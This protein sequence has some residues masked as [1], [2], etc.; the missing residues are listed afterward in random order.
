MSKYPHGHSQL[1]KG[2]IRY[3]TGEV[4]VSFLKPYQTFQAKDMDCKSYYG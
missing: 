3:D 2:C 4:S 1:V